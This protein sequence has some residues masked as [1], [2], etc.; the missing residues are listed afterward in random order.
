MV[1][2]RSVITLTVREI[3]RKSVEMNYWTLGT[4]CAYNMDNISRH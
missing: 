2:S 3:A 1:I 4:E